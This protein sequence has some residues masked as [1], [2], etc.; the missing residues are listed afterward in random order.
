M[1]GSPSSRESRHQTND[2][3]KNRTISNPPQ[4]DRIQQ[5]LESLGDVDPDHLSA[6]LDDLCGND[7]TLRRELESILTS[8]DDIE[9]V[10]QIVSAA[11]QQVVTDEDPLLGAR[12]GAYRITQRLGEGGMSVVYLAYRDDGTFDRAVSLKVMKRGLDT[13]AFLRR[14]ETE[15]RIL[16]NLDHPNI[17]RLYD[18]A[19]TD[20]GRP[21]FVMEHIDGLPL[22]VYVGNHDLPVRR[23]LELFRTVCDAVAYAHQR[24]VVH[25]DLKPANILVTKGGTPKLLDFGIARLLSDERTDI[26]RGEVFLTPDFAS[27]EQIRGDPISTATDQ[28]SLAVLLYL[29]LTGRRPYEVPTTDRAGMER[30]LLNASIPSPS[31][32]RSRIPRDLDS[33]VLKAMRPQAADRYGSVHDLADDIDRHLTGMPVR[34]RKGTMR[35]LAG[36]FL[37]RNRVKLGVGMLLGLLVLVLG[38]QTLRLVHTRARSEAVARQLAE[39]AIVADTEIS[40]VE[41]DPR[42]DL[43]FGRGSFTLTAWVKLTGTSDQPVI[44]MDKRVP[45]YHFSRGFVMFSYENRLGFQLCDG[46]VV[47]PKTGGEPEETTGSTFYLGQ[48]DLDDG[49]WHHVGVSVRRDTLEAR[50]NSLKLFVDGRIDKDHPAYYVR[51][52]DISCSAPLRIGMESDG[53]HIARPFTGTIRRPRVFGRAIDAE[54]MRAR[55]EFGRKTLDSDAYHLPEVTIATGD[56]VTVPLVIQNLGPQRASYTWTASGLPGADGHPPLTRFAPA[57]GMATLA[58][59]P[60]SVTIGIGVNTRDIAAVGWGA[61][62]ASVVNVETLEPVIHYGKIVNE[63]WARKNGLVESPRSVSL[64]TGYAANHATGR[65]PDSSAGSVTHPAAA[66]PHFDPG[67]PLHLEMRV[68]PNGFIT[69]ASVAFDIGLKPRP[70]RMEV[71]AL[72]GRVVRQID[73]GVMSIGQHAVAW[74]GRDDRGHPVPS[75]HYSID[76]LG[77]RPITRWDPQAGTWFRPEE[78][79]RLVTKIVYLP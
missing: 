78:S 10:A 44:I 28:Y 7:A 70:V 74:D 68:R 3:R 45:P 24:L 27:P 15:R 19:S 9:D 37:R 13:E 20:D 33:I 73:L 69:D 16:A 58:P 21:Y 57:S 2:G 59:G 11:A 63:E 52:G 76:I 79:G 35:Y 51:T 23:I 66:Q 5:V 38:M 8:D 49:A 64:A 17:A 18:G 6:R 60:T 53:F 47:H 42:P 72:S 40:F 36:K 77:K 56:S 65:P 30:A 61:F 29:M 46:V 26:T 71:V 34:A 12:L 54:E 48:S 1:T 32:V 62:Q 39:M 31:R 67:I 55:H 50:R 41:A 43:N 4:W 22:D 25:R 75:G 14:F